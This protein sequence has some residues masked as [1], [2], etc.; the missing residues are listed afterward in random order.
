MCVCEGRSIQDKD[1]QRG[2]GGLY[3]FAG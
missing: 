1:G 3:A 2:E